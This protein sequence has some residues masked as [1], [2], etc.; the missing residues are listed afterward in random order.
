MRKFIIFSNG[1]FS[2]DPNIKRSFDILGISEDATYANAQNAY[3]ALSQKAS[4]NEIKELNWAFDLVTEFFAAGGHSES[5]T[6]APTHEPS[7]NIPP[8]PEKAMS[9]GAKAAI[10][11]ALACII[12]LTAGFMIYQTK[13]F[14]SMKSPDTADLSSII[15]KIKPSIVSIN[16]DDLAKGSGFVVSRD[17]YIVTNAHVM[18]EKSA[19]ASFSDGTSVGVNLVFIDPDRDFALLKAAD[20]R[21]FPFLSLGD[22]SLC[23]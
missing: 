12:A 2:I 4:W 5:S 23:T 18:R 7:P 20:T 9:S 11:I 10:I 14:K 21:I 19:K 17:G 16:T 6:F 3:R 22:S 1:V 8:I 15:K 13:V